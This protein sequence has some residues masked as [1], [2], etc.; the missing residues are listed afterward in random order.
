[1][2]EHAESESQAGVDW[3]RGRERVAGVVATVVRWAGLIFALFLAIHVVFVIGEANPDNGIVSFI[4]GGADAFSLGFH[5]LFLP[6]DLKLRVLVNYGLA[7]IF[8]L[9]VSS[10][11]AKVIRRVGGVSG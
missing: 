11:V 7:T 9:V 6:A 5:D 1:M 2:A 8:W 10:I 3:R 4:R